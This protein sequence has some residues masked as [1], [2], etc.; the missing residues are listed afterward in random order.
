M[1]IVAVV[2]VGE[3]T[4]RYY[5]KRLFVRAFLA[6]LRASN[7][8]DSVVGRKGP[9]SSVKD[10]VSPSPS[11]GGCEADCDVFAVGLG[12]GVIAR[13]GGSSF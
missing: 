12:N 7:L 4:V 5:Q 3:R 2:A 6:T 1:A 8:M 11:F 13:S 9:S 10:S